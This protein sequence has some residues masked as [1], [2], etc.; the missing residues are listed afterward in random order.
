MKV[1]IYGTLMKNMRNNYLLDDSKYIG[2]AYILD[3][4]LYAISWFPGIKRKDGYK[5][6]GEIYE[7][8]E[9]T[10]KRLDYYE[11]V[12]SGLYKHTETIAYLGNKQEKVYF[13]EYLGSVNEDK[14]IRNGGKWNGQ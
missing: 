14:L 10:K 7:I 5:V 9:E 11:G 12:D 4:A 3:Y 6:Y 1:F 8:N 2:D 13:Y